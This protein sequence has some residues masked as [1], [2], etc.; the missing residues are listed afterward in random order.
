MILADKLILLRK[1]AGWSQE[2]L[3]EQM[4]VTRQSISKWEGAQSVPDFEKIIRLSELFGVS[5]DYLLKEEIEVEE[6]ADTSDK[7]LRLKRVS[8][9]EANTFLSVKAATSKSIAFAAFLCV[10]SPMGLLIL[11]AMSETAKYNLSENAAGGIGMVILLI[12]VAI[13]VAIFISSGNKTAPFVYLKKEAFETEC[14]VS[15]M[16]KERKS[17][18]NGVYKKNNMIGACLCIM[19]LIPFFAGIAFNEDNVLFLIIMFCIS[20]IFVGI[21]VA[22]FIHGGIVWE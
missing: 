13:A 14:G 15:E 8:M 10:L 9:E 2:E 5:T 7:T 6:Y 1:K 18:Y 12:F 4:N 16:I 19:A 11:A 22:F 17:Q 20:L 21:G 3:A